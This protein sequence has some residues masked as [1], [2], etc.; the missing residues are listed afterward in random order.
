VSSNSHPLS[1]IDKASEL[2]ESSTRFRAMAQLLPYI[3]GALDVLVSGRAAQIQSARLN[4][5]L[6]DLRARLEAIEAVQ[7]EASQELLDYMLGAIET[8][9]RT[10]SS[11]KCARLA[12]LVARQVEQPI[13]WDE[14]ESAQRLLS[15]LEDVHIQVLQAACEAQEATWPYEGLRLIALSVPP[16]ATEQAGLGPVVLPVVFPEYP[17]HLLHMACAEL[18]GRGLITD[19]GIGR[20]DSTSFFYFSPAPLADWFMQRLRTSSATQSGDAS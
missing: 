13:P 8:A 2:Y 1:L 9:V 5:F 12:C 3:G 19:Q 15:H 20:W 18:L 17:H 7:L 16:E 11:A 6:S 14:A 4:R 10:R